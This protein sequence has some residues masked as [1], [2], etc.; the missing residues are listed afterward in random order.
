MRK[1]H[2][3]VAGVWKVIEFETSYFGGAK[4]AI[5]SKENVIEYAK[6]QGKLLGFRES[7]I[8]SVSIIIPLQ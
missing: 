1:F 5:P 8:T 6:D 2:I 7:N 3:K 4:D